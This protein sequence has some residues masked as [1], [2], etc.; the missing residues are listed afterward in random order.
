MGRTQQKKLKFS[1]GEIN[2][3]LLERQDLDILDSSASYIK[4]MVSTPFG[5]ERVREGTKRI[6]IATRQNL[7]VYNE[8]SYRS[9]LTNFQL[10]EEKVMK[11]FDLANYVGQDKLFSGVTLD[12]SGFILYGTYALDSVYELKVYTSPD[13]TAFTLV[14]TINIT[15]QQE[16]PPSGTPQ[17]YTIDCGNS[18]K[19]IRLNLKYID[20]GGL[21]QSNIE[22]I[23]SDATATST[24]A[25]SGV[26]FA[27]FVFNNE[28]KYLLALHDQAINI[29]QDDVLIE[30]VT[31]TGLLEEYFDTLKYTQ[32]QD[33]MVF[34]HPDMSPK[35]LVR[36]ASSW[37]FSDITLEDIPLHPF[38]GETITN[39]AATLTPSALEGS[40]KLTAS[41]SVFSSASVGQLVDG[42]GGRVKI[43]DYESG[44]VVYG[45]TIIPFYSVAGIASGAWDYITGYEA[46]WSASRGYPTTCAFYQERLWFGGSKSLPNNIWGS[47]IAQYY[48]FKNAANYDNDA[49]NVT[50]QSD[51]ID[52][53]VNMHINRG[54][55]IFTGGA[56]WIIPEGATTPG[57]I[58]ISKNTS[59][60]SLASVIPVDIQG[61]TF[62][63]EKNGKSLL[64]FVYSF[65]QNAYTSGTASLLTDLIVDPVGIDVDYNSS[66]DEGNYIY[67]PLS[68]GTMVIGC[69]LVDQQ[70]NA[71]TRFE[72][73]GDIKDVANVSGDTYILVE[74]NSVKYIEKIE[75]Y[76]TYGATDFTTE[77][78]AVAGVVS[79]LSE[80][81]GN[82]VYVYDDTQSYGKHTVSAGS[83]DTGYGDL[84]GTVYVGYGVEFEIIGNKIA[85]NG[86]TNSI[87]KR[88]IKA[89]IITDNTSRLSFRDINNA[90]GHT[91]EE[92]GDDFKFF[93]VGNWSN[94]PRWVISGE[95]DYVEILSVMIYISSGVR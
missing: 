51:Q 50:I 33:V 74:R 70:I 3:K 45:Y 71:Y 24:I 42:N 26:K 59:N 2:H 14:D 43:T 82:D 30:T 39:P 84:D 57:T 15:V 34:T 75:N 73:D 19:H 61:I 41:A 81:E 87:K 92:D 5:S 83:V 10:N 64:S 22:M 94:D 49:I 7:E 16:S 37:T 53:I 44:T 86:K 20:D 78:T 11:S 25:D 18:I 79:N 68:D 21:G 55:Q 66:A 52:E 9:A 95:F 32:S 27:K 36:G 65:D 23:F 91:K 69:L 4:N 77:Q 46:V 28:Q 89:T 29:Y 88:L 31:A 67:M 63:V 35:Q 72:T 54:I 40:V 80:Y 76:V 93:G 38:S 48:N 62:F 1:K 47:R 60:G 6:D 13:N 85:V 12:L 8:T 90:A 58:S 56:E 17:D